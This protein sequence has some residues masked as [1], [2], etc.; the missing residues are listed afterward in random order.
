M[1]F[2]ILPDEACLSQGPHGEYRLAVPVI[3]DDS[4]DEPLDESDWGV[5]HLPLPQD[6]IQAVQ[7]S[8]KA[9]AKR[10][11]TSDSAN[12]V[13]SPAEPL[14]QHSREE[15]APPSETAAVEIELSEQAWRD[16]I[17]ADV[18]S[19]VQDELLEAAS[20]AARKL[21]QQG[22]KKRTKLAKTEI[23]ERK[24]YAKFLVEEAAAEAAAAEAQRIAEEAAARAEAEEQ[25]ARREAL[26]QE[27]LGSAY[28]P[29]QGPSVV[30][31]ASPE[32][33]VLV[34]EE[35]ETAKPLEHGGAGEAA[36]KRASPSALDDASTGVGGGE[37]R[38]DLAT[39]SSVQMDFAATMA[40][41]L[42]GLDAFTEGAE[43]VEGV[44]EDW[45]RKLEETYPAQ[46]CHDLDLEWL[47]LGVTQRE[48]SVR[49]D[50]ESIAVV[51][52]IPALLA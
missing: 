35:G 51:S 7:T 22:L 8:A 44:K 45:H 10:Q 27:K 17:E 25:A 12:E 37:A 29:P 23:K 4:D 20:R 41:P 47:P 42:E 40:S 1:R 14:P 31:E 15:S 43:G 3:Y 2:E 46:P 32:T 24:E 28:V 33:G 48:T 13:A 9:L 38:V 30:E 19:Q 11:A 16:S 6:I 26:R 36:V 5:T 21:H 49:S 50:R 52:P 18:R 34:V 39:E